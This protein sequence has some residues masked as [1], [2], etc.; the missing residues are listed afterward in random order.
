MLGKCGRKS[1]SILSY[2]WLVEHE[3]R[4]IPIGETVYGSYR[5][6]WVLRNENGKLMQGLT[7]ENIFI[8]FVVMT[9]E[10]H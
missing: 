6:K 8:T 7:L 2:P 10:Y 3:C 5:A 4:G 9:S 1:V